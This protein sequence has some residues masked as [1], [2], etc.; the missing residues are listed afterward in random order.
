MTIVDM[1]RVNASISVGMCLIFADLQQV[2]YIC[3]INTN[4]TA[5]SWL[6]LVFVFY[7][8][9]I[10]SWSVRSNAPIKRHSH[11]MAKENIVIGQNVLRVNV[12]EPEKRRFTPNINI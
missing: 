10:G 3:Y 7:V 9:L 4:K 11:T 1:L 5:M 6:R 12:T 2:M 8:P